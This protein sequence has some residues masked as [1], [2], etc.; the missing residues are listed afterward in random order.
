M[1]W[2]VKSYVCIG[3]SNHAYVLAGH[4]GLEFKI[5]CLHTVCTGT[6]VFIHKHTLVSH[7]QTFFPL[8]SDRKKSGHARL[9]MHLHVNVVCNMYVI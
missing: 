1:C 7:G 3:W 4:M 2:L 9:S 6:Y 5:N 8:Y